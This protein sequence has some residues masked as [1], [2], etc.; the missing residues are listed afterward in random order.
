MA[1]P[2]FIRWQINR[3]ITNAVN[4]NPDAHHHTAHGVA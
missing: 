3:A 4:A 1:F 2:A